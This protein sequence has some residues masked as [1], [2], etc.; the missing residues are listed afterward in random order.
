[1]KPRS[2]HYN[3]RMKRSRL[4]GAQRGGTV[5]RVCAGAAGLAGT[6]RRGW[7]QLL[8]WWLFGSLW[9]SSRVFCA[10]G[11]FSQPGYSWGAPGHTETPPVP[12]VPGQGALQGPTGCGT[13]RPGPGPAV[14]SHQGPR[15]GWD[16]QLEKAQAV[17]RTSPGGRCPRSVPAPPPAGERAATSGHGRPRPPP[18]P[19]ARPRTHLAQGAEEQLLGEG[20]AGRGR[21]QA[22]GW[23]AG[24]GPGSGGAQGPQQQ[25]HR[26]H[27][28]ARRSVTA[29]P[30]ARPAPGRDTAPAPHSPTGRRFAR[31][32][33][34]DGDTPHEGSSR[35][36]PQPQG[37]TGRRLAR[38]ARG[39]AV[40]PLTASP[41]R[42]QARFGPRC[43]PLP[44]PA[45]QLLP[46]PHGAT[47]KQ[48]LVHP[49]SL[50]VAFLRRKQRR[51]PGGEQ[52][53]RQGSLHARLELRDTLRCTPSAWKSPQNLLNPNLAPPAPCVRS[54]SRMVWA[55]PALPALLQPFPHVNKCLRPV[56]SLCPAVSAA[57]R[58][59]S[60][61]LLRLPCHPSGNRFRLF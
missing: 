11:P 8:P 59:A 5:P 35:P 6:G 36:A 16:Q 55:A 21:A 15:P 51:G 29:P 3:Q 30:S 27:G 28:R 52:Q 49:G 60:P 53:H 50:W 47:G 32:D 2:L 17:L 43:P 40:T 19:P 7:A 26:A 24:P 9:A 57:L 12:S 56:C 10:K 42:P 4:S 44:C 20:A 25:Q 46:E 1:M 48:P 14:G 41:A 22:A 58:R 13:A 33:R 54:R 18:S 37:P 39:S 45:R 61:L 34:G 31:R 38:R 23:G